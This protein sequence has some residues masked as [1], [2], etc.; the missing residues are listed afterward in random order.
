MAS[1]SECISETVQRG[2]NASQRPTTHIAQ[3]SASNAPR[4]ASASAPV[5]RCVLGEVLRETPTTVG[6][7]GVAVVGVVAEGVVVAGVVTV[8]VVEGGV[9]VVGTLVV[10]V[11]VVGVAPGGTVPG[12]A[13][14]A[15]VAV[16]V[17]GV[18]VDVPVVL[19]RAEAGTDNPRCFSAVVEFAAAALAGESAVSATSAHKSA[20]LRGG[21]LRWKVVIPHPC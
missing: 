8:G 5:E 9:V 21:A 6:V 15:G 1:R 10:G 14:L 11:A 4:I 12:W 17:V 20:S 19:V 3:P 13:P 2:S 18:V 16:V 7:P